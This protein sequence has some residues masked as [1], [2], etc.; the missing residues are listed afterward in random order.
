MRYI[1]SWNGAGIAVGLLE[2]D[3]I[4]E[5]FNFAHNT[6][7]TNIQEDLFYGVMGFKS[8]KQFWRFLILKEYLPSLMKEHEPSKKRK[9][10]I[11]RN[12]FQNVRK[13]REK[14]VVYEN[15]IRQVALESTS[16]YGIGQY[17]DEV[18]GYQYS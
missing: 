14:D 17:Q 6:F 18:A 16:Y 2:K 5:E 13:I 1:I 10:E 12:C 4:K 3:G 11:L 7:G 8:I 9:N 15:F